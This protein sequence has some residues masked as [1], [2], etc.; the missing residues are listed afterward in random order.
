MEQVIKKER[1]VKGKIVLTEAN[2]EKLQTWKSLFDKWNDIVKVIKSDLVNFILSQTPETLSL[3]E[4]K[5]LLK[6]LVNQNMQPKTRKPRIKKASS[7][8]KPISKESESI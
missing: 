2:N 1:K 6:S 7:F 3:N 8:V 5:T 4:V